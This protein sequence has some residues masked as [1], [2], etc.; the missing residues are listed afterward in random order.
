MPREAV[1][2]RA[3]SEWYLC[4]L[5]T[6]SLVIVESPAKATKIGKILGSDYVVESSVGHIRDLPANASEVPAEHKG[7]SWASMG[8][9][10]EHDFEP[11]YVIN[12]GKKKTVA[13]L[14]KLL[15]GVD[16][17]VLATDKDREGEAIAWHLLQVLNPKVPVKRMVFGEITDKAIQEAIDNTIELDERMVDAQEARRIL[18]RLYGYELSPVLWKKVNPGL[19]AGRVQSVATRIIVERERERMAFVSAN[20]W[21]LDAQLSK[22]GTP[23]FESKMS[24]LSDSRLASG[25][26]FDQR[27]PADGAMTSNGWDQPRAEALQ[28]G[29]ADADFTVT[30]VETKPYRRKAAGNRSRPRPC[31]RMPAGSCASR[32][33]GRC[34]SPSGCTRT[35]TSP[36]CARTRRCCPTPRSTRRAPRSP[37][38]TARTTCRTHHASTPRS[39]RTRRRR[40]RRSVPRATRSG[41]RRRYAMSWAPRNGG[42][43]S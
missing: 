19:S 2:A 28:A 4:Y 25:K 12:S 9:D 29:L 27:G 37:R 41:P 21:D 34:R 36:T 33:S 38:S 24:A 14:R 7:K 42:C 16:E 13:T 10:T 43:T 11:V 6:K 1:C 3:S 8:V 18:D 35:A 31:S 32:P 22:Q 20:Y 17:L 5:M 26:D 30:S 23:A 40:M 15:K 39:P